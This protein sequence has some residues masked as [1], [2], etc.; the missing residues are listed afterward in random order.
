MAAVC[1][2][3]VRLREGVMQRRHHSTLDGGVGLLQSSPAGRQAE[4][5]GAEQEE[6]HGGDVHRSGLPGSEGRSRIH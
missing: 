4:A 2:M 6:R 3:H 1:G 5:E